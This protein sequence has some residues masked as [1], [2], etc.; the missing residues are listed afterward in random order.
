MK[1]STTVRIPFS[2]AEELDKCVGHFGWETRSQV[3]R[4][5]IQKGLPATLEIVEKDV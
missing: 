3:A 2:L 5:L 4:F 1:K